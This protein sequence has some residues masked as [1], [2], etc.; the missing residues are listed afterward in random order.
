M[1]NK[2][3]IIFLFF[4]FFLS[5]SYFQSNNTEKDFFSLSSKE[6]ESEVY[7]IEL[8]KMISQFNQKTFNENKDIAEIM[9]KSINMLSKGI[10]LEKIN[11]EKINNT[12]RLIEK[13]KIGKVA[14]LDADKNIEEIYE[15]ADNDFILAKKAYDDGDYWKA[16][17]LFG[18]ITSI[19][20]VTYTK[21]DDAYYYSAL[22]YFH[23]ELF[24]SAK[25]ALNTLILEIPLSDFF[26]KAYLLLFR[27]NYYLKKY[28]DNIFSAD[29][30]KEKFPDSDSLNLAHYYKG[31]SYM[32]LS[33]FEQAMDN[34]RLVDTTGSVYYYSRYM[35]GLCK[36]LSNDS[37]AAFYLKNLGFIENELNPIPD[38]LREKILLTSA[39]N[40]FE[41]DS[42]E[43]ASEILDS[44]EN[45]S[46]FYRDELLYT[47]G[48][49]FFQMGELDSA[50]VYFL[51]VTE[52]FETSKFIF[53]SYY[54]LISI[55]KEQLRFEDANDY[56]VKL[57]KIIE[58]NQ[59]YGKTR[60][61][62]LMNINS[63]DQ[64]I[65]LTKNK[66]SILDILT[67]D[68]FKYLHYTDYYN[69]KYKSDDYLEEYTKVLKEQFIKNIEN[70][71]YFYS[72]ID[73]M[74]QYLN[75]L[76][77]LEKVEYQNAMIAYD[78][79]NK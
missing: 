54:K 50:S 24:Y 76:A 68:K 19:Y 43:K 25:E 52:E 6:L 15:A 26:E 55:A 65:L 36:Y 72:E 34:F 1:N 61:E 18:Q 35:S 44:V 4:S 17:F 14:V 45:L 32:E 69:D 73:L 9:E 49:V 12:V 29:E 22:S 10:M 77:S 41:I 30:F 28:E 37:I 48:E 11:I 51:K 64:E 33:R 42:L 8:E 58:E 47:H 59:Y 16:A 63:R 2:Y 74:N 40:Y 23:E 75:M 46:D 57:K 39:Q 20:P 5:C 38:D 60:S 70:I 67:F 13:N 66:N 53:E 27:T 79:I 7:N 21:L 78:K 71:R 62:I 56:Y 3:L 31:L